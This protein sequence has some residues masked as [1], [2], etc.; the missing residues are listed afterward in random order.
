MRP[1]RRPLP[2]SPPE[3]E[4]APAVP[5]AQPDAMPDNRPA[6]G[7]EPAAVDA[8][9]PVKA[10]KEMPPS[11]DVAAAAPVVPA[12]PVP[13][14]RAA[15]LAAFN[16]TRTPPSPPPAPPQPPRPAPPQSRQV[17]RQV[18]RPPERQAI[19]R[20]GW[21][22]LVSGFVAGNVNWN[23]KRLG[24]PPGDPDCRAPRDLLRSFGL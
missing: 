7:P 11:P 17:Q 1:R 6:N 22:E 14:G 8:K 21:E 4:S 23:T 24:A 12:V 20:G 13:D 18:E 16:R 15:V 3:P 10:S 2:I 5:P 9:P 19:S